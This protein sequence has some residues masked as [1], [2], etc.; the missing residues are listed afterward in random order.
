VYSDPTEPARRR[1]IRIRRLLGDGKVR[2]QRSSN[3]LELYSAPTGGTEEFG[4]NDEVALDPGTYWLQGGADASTSVRG[5]EL[6]VRVDD[7]NAPFEDDLKATVI[8][9]DISAKNS[10]SRSANPI[11]DG[12]AAIQKLMG[13]TDLGV[14]RAA[15]QSREGQKWVNGNI[16][17]QGTL[18]PNDL[19]QNAFDQ[20][21]TSGFHDGSPAS[22]DF[23]F[24]FRRF[25]TLRIYTNGQATV[26][27]QMDNQS[28]D[29]DRIFQD[30]NPD[31]DAG[32][33]RII[34]GDG[35][36]ARVSP[37]N[38]VF[39]G[40]TRDNFDEHIAF[41]FQKG[42]SERVS[43]N[44]QWAFSGDV[45]LSYDNKA[46]FIRSAPNGGGDIN[47]VKVGSHLPNV[48]LGIA[49]PVLQRAST[50]A[51]DRVIT[52]NQDVV[53]TLVGTNLI[54]D[55]FLVKAGRGGA[56]VKAKLVQVK[57]TDPANHVSDLTE[58]RATFNTDLA[59]GGGY[60]LEIRNAAGTDAVGGFKIRD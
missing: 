15:Q 21:L 28:D 41:V 51:G 24:I 23:G 14:V 43:E 8:W 38:S 1:E 19:T 17:V 31:L 26:V 58:I 52:R 53:V 25:A 48:N 37:A 22:A 46:V 56:E 3:H 12:A 34:D 13:N 42:I 20:Q 60:K 59:A 9:A 18:S 33:L 7:T 57:E 27:Q 5:D 45:A 36:T 47:V 39:F 2:V 50:A 10:G 4:G 55:V 44:L 16:E 40:H 6:K 54:G 29:S 30:V 35:P 11:Y 49:A 32:N